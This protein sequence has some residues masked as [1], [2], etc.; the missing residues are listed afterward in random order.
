MI[1]EGT[2]LE[3]VEVFAY[4]SRVIDKQGGM[5]ADVRDGIGKVQEHVA[6]QR[7]QP[8]NKAQ[9]LQLIYQIHSPLRFRDM[10]NNKYNNNK[11]TTCTTAWGGN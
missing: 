6:L 4:T 1:L 2:A 9:T 7:K 10:K 11:S 8:V 3:E 5:D